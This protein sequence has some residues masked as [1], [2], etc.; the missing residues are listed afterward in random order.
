MTRRP[1]GQL[2]GEQGTATVLLLLLTPA[3][4]ALA[5]LVL[6]G[7]TALSARQR[8][9][10]LAEQ[11]ARAGA[12]RL[13]T[14]ALR[15]TGTGQ[16]DP[17]AARTAACGYVHTVEPG[18][19]C[20]ATIVLAATGQAVTV[21]VRTSTP[22]VLLGLIGVNAFHADGSATAEAVTGVRLAGLQHPHLP[23]LLLRTAG[24]TRW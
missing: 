1:R 19:T 3:V 9:A 13:D 7:G 16:L 4:L 24:D 10:D 2:P 8:S 18:A 22:T 15:A 11:A 20:T 21:H 5:G 14:S 12:D 17:G 6:D 23:L